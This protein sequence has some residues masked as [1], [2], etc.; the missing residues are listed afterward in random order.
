MMSTDTD[1]LIFRRRDAL[2]LEARVSPSTG[3]P[4][5]KHHAHRN[6]RVQE[7]RQTLRALSAST[8][9]RHLMMRERLVGCTRHKPCRL[10]YCPACTAQKMRRTEERFTRVL[11]FYPD[12]DLNFVTIVLGICETGREVEILCRGLKRHLKQLSNDWLKDTGQSLPYVGQ[13]EVDIVLATGISQE[14]GMNSYKCLSHLNA[15]LLQRHMTTDAML[16]KPHV[17]MWVAC[18][19]GNRLRAR[20]K[21]YGAGRHGNGTAHW[22]APFQVHICGPKAG[23]SRED[24]I[25]RTASYVHKNPKRMND[26]HTTQKIRLLDFDLKTE[27]GTTLFQV[28]RPKKIGQ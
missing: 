8:D 4:Y 17:H 13:I 19:D 6:R 11:E 23:Q 3:A 27:L 15:E 16:L 22:P 25:R 10:P 12:A 24:R 20:I 1:D 28:G 7:Y 26:K 14:T 21:S 18:A 2:P 9:S 5:Q